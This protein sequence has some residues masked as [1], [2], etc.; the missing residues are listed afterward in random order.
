MQI[1]P[2]RTAVL[3]IEFQND[4]AS[5]GGNLHDAVKGVMTSNNMLQNTLELVND[6]RNMG[7][8][9]IHA[10][11]SFKQGY[12]ELSENPYGILKGVVDTQSFVKGTWGA[13]IIPS[14]TPQPTDIIAEGKRGLCVFSSTN[15]DFILRSKGIE[16]LAVAGFLTNCCVESTLRSGYE[17]GFNVIGLTD[18]TAATSEIE[19]QISTEKN[20]PMFSR[21]MTKN[22]FMNAVR[23]SNKAISAG[24]GYAP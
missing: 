11:I 7:L 12:T 21:P 24:R 13:E 17:K 18:C 14:L 10:P 1:D 4:F 8:T 16:T 5:E 6:A 22:D 9:V 23:G 19:Q 3:L 20:Y 2:K 15:L